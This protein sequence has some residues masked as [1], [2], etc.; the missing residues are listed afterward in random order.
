MAGT[1]TRVT[2][3]AQQG[4]AR[5]A[6]TAT[7]EAG[8][9]ASIA[10]SA[11]SDVAETAKDQ[12]AAV[13]GEAREQARDLFEQTRAQVTEQAI[14]AADKLGQSLRELSHELIAM[15]EGS[16]DGQGPT[17]ELVRT[18]GLKGESFADTLS[19]QGPGGVVGQLRQMAGRSPGTFLLGALAA[20]VVAGRLTRGAKASSGGGTGNSSSSGTTTAQPYPSTGGL[21]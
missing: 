7:D 2:G 18:L 13:V 9:V 5:T 3:S 17:A 15:G 6:H 11:A 21:A 4:A 20:G 16:G 19:Q 8:Q 14:S 10:G 1:T 12:A